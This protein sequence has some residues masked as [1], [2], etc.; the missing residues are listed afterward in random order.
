MWLCVEV[1]KSQRNPRLRLGAGRSILTSSTR[2]KRG[3]RPPWWKFA[4]PHG[5]RY[6]VTPGEG[7]KPMLSVDQVAAI[8]RT[9][10][11]ALRR[12]IRTP[13]FPMPPASARPL[14][15]TEGQIERLLWAPQDHNEHFQKMQRR[16]SKAKRSG[17]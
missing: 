5:E 13:D 12:A 1:S 4:P 14:R 3:R 9:T 2:G 15:W 7:E 8:L 11:Q 16:Q 10:P 17:R 6:R